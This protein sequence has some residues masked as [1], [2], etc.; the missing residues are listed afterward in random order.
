MNQQNLNTCP[1]CGT[2]IEDGICPK[3]GYIQLI[4][5]ESIPEQLRQQEL[6]RVATAKKRIGEIDSLQEQNKVIK[7]QS[8]QTIDN[9][10]RLIQD[11]TDLS[12]QSDKDINDLKSKLKRAESDYRKSESMLSDSNAKLRR[13]ESKL[14]QSESE[15]EGLIKIISTKNSEIEKVK[16]ELEE[17]GTKSNN[18]AFL[19]LTDDG[20]LSVLPIA[21]EKRFYATGPGMALCPLPESQIIMLPVMTSTR[22]AFSIEKS[23][24]GGFRLTDIAGNIN[25]SGST[26]GNRFRLTQGVIIKIKGTNMQFHFCI[27]QE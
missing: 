20:E 13:L 12:E 15:I 8:Q 17:I 23:A 6:M 14:A 2:N 21:N 10:K 25:S 11:K 1:I 16:R 24:S 26:S 9:L 27:N 19:I 3:C 5:P 18:N 7:Q 22:V 4:F